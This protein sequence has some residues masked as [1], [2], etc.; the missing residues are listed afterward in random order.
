MKP[1]KTHKLGM[2]GIVVLVLLYLAHNDF[3]N[4]GEPRL[5]LG[6]P[7]TFVY[8]ISYCLVVALVFSVLTRSLGSSDDFP[9]ESE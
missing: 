6:L 5:F 9:G 3:W 8:H 1:V 2:G 4:W 7:I